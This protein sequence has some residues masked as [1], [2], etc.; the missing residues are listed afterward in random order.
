MC[1]YH[2][3]RIEIKIN[4]EKLDMKTEFKMKKKRKKGRNYLSRDG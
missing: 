3:S 2:S 4:G 1:N